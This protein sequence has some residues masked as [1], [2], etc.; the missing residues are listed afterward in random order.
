MKVFRLKRQWLAILLVL[1]VSTGSLGCQTASDNQN[2]NSKI[3]FPEPGKT[4]TLVVPYAPGGLVDTSLRDLQPFF[5][6]ELGIRVEVVNTPGAGGQIAYN[7]I[8]KKPADGYTI[9]FS[10]TP[11]GPHTFPNFN[12]GNTSWKFD[13]FRAL[14]FF[15]EQANTGLLTK[16]NAPWKSFTDLILNA[17]KRPGEI[18][19]GTLGPGRIDDLYIKELET[20]FKVEFNKVFYDS[21]SSLSTDLLTGDIDV[22]LRAAIGEGKNPNLKILTF[23]ASEY[24]DGFPY[25]D[26]P[27]IADFQESLN[28]NVKDLKIL[29]KRE[30]S[31]LVVKS[32]VPDEIVNVLSQAL[33]NIVANPKWREKAIKYSAPVWYPPDEAQ[34]TSSKLNES[35]G[36]LLK[37]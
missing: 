4:L 34:E 14:G 24:P 22:A 31:A 26:I 12:A 32:D 2:E 16:A 7:D 29:G 21:G 1:I 27:N 37:K 36:E 17:R 10:G 19:V 15:S 28:F 11:F 13:D 9:T 33:E 3:V 5:A 35:I 23:I 30:W 6:E 25:P 8:F 20:V 18:T